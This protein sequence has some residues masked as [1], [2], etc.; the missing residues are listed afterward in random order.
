MYSM[1]F[2]VAAR[3]KS[4]LTVFVA[5]KCNQ[6]VFRVPHCRFWIKVSS[7]LRFRIGFFITILLP[8]N[9]LA[10]YTQVQSYKFIFAGVAQW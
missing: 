3:L 8:K 2:K 4:R 7:I 10:L 5:D 6:T 9:A 1:E